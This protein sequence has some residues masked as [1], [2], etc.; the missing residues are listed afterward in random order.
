MG[1]YR[2]CSRSYSNTSAFTRSVHRSLAISL[3]NVTTTN[4][5]VIFWYDRKI[6]TSRHKSNSNV[7]LSELTINSSARIS[8]RQFRAY[9][10]CMRTTTF[11]SV[12]CQLYLTNCAINIQHCRGYLFRNNSLVVY[13]QQRQHYNGLQIYSQFTKLCDRVDVH[14]NAGLTLMHLLVFHHLSRTQYVFKVD[15]MDAVCTP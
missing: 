15:Y 13:E 12:C 11:W 5:D 7:N 10:V 3:S 6:L 9:F 4:C 14:S 8:T 2:E 1:T